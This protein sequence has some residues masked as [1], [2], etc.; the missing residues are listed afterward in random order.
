[1]TPWTA[2]APPRICLPLATLGVLALATPAA[3]C[4]FAAAQPQVP[5]PYALFRGTDCELKSEYST[6]TSSTTVQLVLT[7]PGPD[8]SPSPAWLV[9]Q[10]EYAGTRPD[11]PPADISITA[12]PVV[13]FNPNVVRGVELD[14]VI[15]TTEAK[16]VTLSYFGRAVGE[17]G[18]V[19]AGGEISRVAFTLSVTELRALL[20]AEQVTGRVMNSDFALTARELA[21]LRLFAST[22][23]VRAGKGPLPTR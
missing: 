8:G 15:E 23:G 21:T 13:N 9:L 10:A 19:P 14:L 1:M 17:F 20:A 12:L 2:V 16:R 4:V 3:V 7:P 6:A 11:L 5:A 18:F 22:I